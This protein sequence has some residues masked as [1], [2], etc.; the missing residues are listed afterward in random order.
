MNR[1]IVDFFETFIII[2][3][4][5]VL[6]QTFLEDFAVLA[7]WTWNS[8][9]ILIFSGFAFDFI[10]TVE[11]LVRYFTALSRGEAGYYFLEG[12]GWIDF[13]AS[14][15]LLLLNSGPAFLSLIFG[16]SIVFGLGSM[17][18]ILKIVKAIRIARIL[19]L[20]RILKLFRK[21]KYI[22]SPMAQR[23]ITRINTLAISTV[24]FTLFT[25]ALIVGFFSLPSSAE[26]MD[27]QHHAGIESFLS[28]S[29]GG[30][31]AE[32]ARLFSTYDPDLLIVKRNGAT[33]FSRYDNSYYNRQFGFGDF[34]FIHTNGWSFFFNN[35]DVLKVQSVY[36]ILFFFI[37]VILVIA[38]LIF[39]SPHFAFT[40]TDPVHVMER[41][42]SEP[43]YNLEVEIPER[44]KDD[45][46]YRLGDLYNRKYLPLKQRTVFEEE[47]HS[48]L[49]L[50]DFQDLLNQDDDSSSSSD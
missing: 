38:I 19:R 50:D 4:L 18:N 22:T 24:V 27:Q 36:N 5:L 25:S 40:I 13:L 45:D 33:I 17:F 37:V 46:I 30:P 15:P 1:K 43:M 35:M 20:L 26:G 28:S 47:K 10:F 32:K 14:I 6:V 11:F 21:I 39:Y 23:H 44:Y 2:A 48:D 12:R 41:G 31:S 7:G 3:I 9:R 29:G 16:G 42:F 8:R 49:T 34:S